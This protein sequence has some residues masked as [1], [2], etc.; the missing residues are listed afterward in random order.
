MISH[1]Y[2]HISLLLNNRQMPSSIK[3]RML[4]YRACA[5][6]CKFS[7][8]LIAKTL[9]K[10]S[11]KVCILA[12][13][14]VHKSSSLGAHNTG[15]LPSADVDGTWQWSTLDFNRVDQC[16]AFRCFAIC[17]FRCLIQADVAVAFS[18]ILHCRD[19][20]S[21]V[22]CGPTV[23]TL[24]PCWNHQDCW[25]TR[26][27]ANC[28]WSRLISE[29]ISAVVNFGEYVVARNTSSWIEQFIF[30]A[31]DE[32]STS[33]VTTKVRFPLWIFRQTQEVAAA[34]AFVVTCSCCVSF[35][36]CTKMFYYTVNYLTVVTLFILR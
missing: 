8:W 28:T 22:L 12:W 25:T 6:H 35:N 26:R 18:R 21:C 29:W 13:Q 33:V 3:T 30:N 10:V 11:L 2:I 5:S 15:Q 27:V 7:C 34:A 23:R 1:T 20:I 31:V 19:Q 14:F 4:Q 36:N 9:F 32:S 16:S 24:C 17:N